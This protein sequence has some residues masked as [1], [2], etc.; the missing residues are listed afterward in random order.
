MQKKITDS[1]S[2]KVFL[3]SFIVQF[4]AGMLICLV[5]YSRTPEMLYSPVEELADI[6]ERLDSLTPGQAT[7]LID[8]YIRRTGVDIAIY[9]YDGR[10]AIMYS[11]PVDIIGTL[12]LKTRAE[13]DA[14]YDKLPDNSG[15][16]GSF[17]F[18]LKNDPKQYTLLYFYYKD[19]ENL[20][21]RALANSYPLMI[22]VVVTVSLISSAIYTVLFALPV[23]RLSKASHAMAGMDFTPFEGIV[24]YTFKLRIHY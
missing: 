8:D 20:V 11:E 22:L 23:K 7:G 19:K 13:T 21:P 12:T 9:D 10:G 5:L 1:L 24:T 17:M 3:I 18:G 14:A 16:L 15:D 2:F 4:L 6:V